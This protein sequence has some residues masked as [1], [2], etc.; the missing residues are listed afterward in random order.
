MLITTPRGER[1]K[2]KTKV[3]VMDSAKR[4]DLRTGCTVPESGIYR[5]SHPQHRLPD[6]VTLLSNQ[7]FPRC[8]RCSDPVFYK[9]VRSAPAAGTSH[10]EPFSITLYELP[11]LPSDELAS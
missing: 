5:V 1:M 9:L 7:S 8:S 4:T 6:E 11:E 10:G 3:T 2:Y